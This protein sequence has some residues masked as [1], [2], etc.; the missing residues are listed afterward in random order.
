MCNRYGILFFLLVLAKAHLLYGQATNIEITNPTAE[1]ILLGNFDPAEFAAGTPLAIETEWA[2]LLIDNLEPDSLKQYL[3]ELNA[4][5]NRNTGSD[6][7]SSTFGM[8]AARRWAVSRMEEF[9]S[10]NNDRLQVGYVQF[11]EVVCGMD[12]HRNVLG[13]LPGTG[14]LASEVIL[15]EAHMDSRCADQ[16]DVDC[17]ADGMEDNGS[18]V[19]LVL[20]LARVMS[21]YSFDRSIAFML[22][23]GEEQGLI[24]AAALADYCVANE[25]NLVAVQNNDIVGGVICG[26]TA[27][28]PG[29][30][31][32]NEIDSINV[33]L[34]SSNGDSKNF[35]RYTKL[36]YDTHVAPLLQEPSI[37]NIMV[38]EDRTGRGG[39]HI[40]FRQRGYPAI[41]FTSANEHGDAGVSDPN[42]SDRQH[43]TEDVLGID[44]DGDSVLDSFFVDFRYL[45]RNAVINGFTAGLIT[46]A[47]EPPEAMDLERID[48][49]IGIQIT[50]SLQRDSFTL[51]IRPTSGST[52]WDTL[53]RVA[54]VDTIELDQERWSITVAYV[55]ERGISSLHA[56][57]RS[58]RILVSDT[59]EFVEETKAIE[60]LPN[61]PN[62]FDEATM[63][64]VFVN[65]SVAAQEGTLVVHDRAGKQLANLP[66]S[67][68][69]GLHEVLYDFSNHNFVQGIYSYSLVVEGQI[70]ATQQMIYAY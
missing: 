57:E 16:C 6:T 9:S 58:I 48:Y 27:S 12:Q 40:P 62:P 21:K 28:P 26:N 46:T 41:R 65:R 34:Y 53:I 52:Y 50:D 44:T 70:L 67:L 42:Y 32:L 18:G 47:P 54:A 31:G 1:R 51:G 23:T 19:A 43:T 59:E 13:V 22:T 20:E 38:G 49:R 35:A 15:I 2:Q 10:R 3:L 45:Y 56:H 55:D 33:R 14:I 5:G 64:R 39:D 66:V 24:G 37:V 29:C 68:S 8:G 69:P 61:Y 7:V 11:D 4:F 63:L 30:P 25:V 36:G 17:Q 60:L